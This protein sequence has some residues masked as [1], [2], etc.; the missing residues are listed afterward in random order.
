MTEPGETPFFA[1]VWYTY[2]CQFFLLEK[3]H[4]IQ[5][6]MAG[7]LAAAMA[8]VSLPQMTAAETY[9][10][11][12]Y[13][14][15]E[16][17]SVSITKYNK[18]YGEVEIPD[19]IDGKTVTKIGDRAFYLCTRIYM[20]TIPDSDKEIG[21]RAFY[22]CEAITEIVI[23]DG[24][25]EIGESTFEHC[26]ALA[27]IVIP[28]S[29]TDI[30]TLAFYMCSADLTIYGYAGS[31]AE[32]FANQYDMPF[33]VI[34]RTEVIEDKETGILVTDEEGVLP[35][36]AELKVELD[37]AGSTK[38]RVVYNI[39]ITADGQPINIDG[40]VTVTIPVPEELKGLEEYYVFYRDKDGK[41]TDMNAVYDKDTNCVTFTTDHFSE[42]ILA[43]RDLT[44]TIRG[45]VNGS[46]GEPDNDDLIALA[47][48]L[49]QWDV[50]I[51]LEA[52]NVDGKGEIDND[53]LIM[54]AQI[55]ANWNV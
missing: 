5:K 48:Y 51:D 45:D 43:T 13:E 40:T 4:E 7:A 53:D 39:T 29:V 42:F 24:V 32:E 28:D 49:A 1:Y 15:L 26:T 31:Y 19:T 20:I 18:S 3:K 41:L 38:D 23:P 25:T 35:E 9:E 17:G 27:K 44:A 55:L 50:K 52:A 36:N 11:F 21:D 2:F 47:Q 8:L 6:I 34:E 46:G 14:V 16:D 37:K 54:L 22:G 12:E 10:D 30:D 33:V